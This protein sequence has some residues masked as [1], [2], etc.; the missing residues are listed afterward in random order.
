MCFLA[1]NIFALSLSLSMKFLFFEYFEQSQINLKYCLFSFFFK[2][3]F[4]CLFSESLSLSPTL[5][6]NS[7][8]PSSSSCKSA[9]GSGRKSPISHHAA[10]HVVVVVVVVVVRSPNRISKCLAPSGRTV[11][12]AISLIKNLKAEVGSENLNWG[13][14]VGKNIGLTFRQWFE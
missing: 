7:L 11:S 2:S 1:L 4:H 8:S 12:I 13:K 10:S 3:P 5:K 6:V 14:K 9:C